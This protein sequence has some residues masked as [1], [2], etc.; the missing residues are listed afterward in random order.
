[1]VLMSSAR[2]SAQSSR[3]VHASPALLCASLPCTAL[4]CCCPFCAPQSNPAGLC[5]VKV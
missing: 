2:V 5:Q 3:V 1:M 4:C